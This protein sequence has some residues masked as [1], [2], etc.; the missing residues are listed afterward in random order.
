MVLRRIFGSKGNE[1]TGDWRKL[2][3]E[4]FICWVLYIVLIL[5]PSKHKF[6][7]FLVT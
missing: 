6:L 1:V 3:N 2:Y 5:L 4:D 7:L